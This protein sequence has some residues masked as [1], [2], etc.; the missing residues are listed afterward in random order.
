MKWT[1]G[2]IIFSVS[3]LVVLG[4]LA[5]YSV[6]YSKWDGTRSSIV[7]MSAD[8]LSAV[9]VAEAENAV[10]KE[11]SVSTRNIQGMDSFKRQAFFV[12]L[13][14][15]CCAIIALWF[16]YKLLQQKWIQVVLLL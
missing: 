2:L 13:G 14:A 5:L 10:D 16:D 12:L 7:L 8:S 6:T 9:G 3:L 15:V 11:W 4:L 1:V